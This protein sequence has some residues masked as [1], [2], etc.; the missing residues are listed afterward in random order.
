MSKKTNDTT[1]Q[2]PALLEDAKA[3]QKNQI[4]LALAMPGRPLHAFWLNPSQ[5]TLQNATVE[6]VLAMNAKGKQPA[7]IQALCRLL[8]TANA[9]AL[10]QVFDK[11]ISQPSGKASGAVPVD[12]GFLGLDD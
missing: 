5:E 3:S 12:L 11:N 9:S 7:E 8:G 6:L 10:R 4:L 1:D 2:I